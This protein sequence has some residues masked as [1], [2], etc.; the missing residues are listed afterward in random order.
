MDPNIRAFK[1]Q[2]FSFIDELQEM[3]PSEKKIV[4]YREIF[5]ACY[6][7]N[8]R[9]TINKYYETVSPYKL[10]IINKD[11]QFFEECD[12]SN[13]SKEGKDALYFRS[14]VK[15]SNLSD[16][17]LEPIWDYLAVLCVLSERVHQNS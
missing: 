11:K 14:I 15:D 10:Q 5:E 17:D 12:I 4:A 1:T 16:D 7:T 3:F 2:I 9:Q 8:P 13:S 6:K